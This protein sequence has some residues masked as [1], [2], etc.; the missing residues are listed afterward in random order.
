MAKTKCGNLIRAP[1]YQLIP[2][3]GGYL[4]DTFSINLN[5]DVFPKRNG[6]DDNSNGILE[7]PV[8]DNTLVGRYNKHTK[9]KIESPIIQ[10]Y[11]IIHSK[12][13]AIILQPRVY[14][15]KV[16]YISDHI[17]QADINLKNLQLSLINI[18]AP[19]KTIS[20]EFPEK[21]EKFYKDLERTVKDIYDRKL[22]NIDVD[23]T[24]AR[25]II[26][27]DFDAEVKAELFG[28][29]DCLRQKSILKYATNANNT[30][31]NNYISNSINS[32]N[33]M[34]I[35]SPNEFNNKLVDFAEKNNFE[36]VSI[37]GNVNKIRNFKDSTFSLET[38]EILSD[39][40]Q[41]FLVSP[42]VRLLTGSCNVDFKK[43]LLG[44]GWVFESYRFIF[45]E[46]FQI[47]TSFQTYFFK[48]FRPNI[49]I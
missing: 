41:H 27:G 26:G 29:Y 7:L 45:F 14:L 5:F 35:K 42:Y 39:R 18:K 36:I 4:I 21:I 24:R 37:T 8:K 10:K 17:L 46:K 30:I 2:S 33:S 23:P 9:Q 43:G 48:N 20:K 6:I 12:N 19:D 38:N 25:I 47:T 16:E 1:L 15:T 3:G 40:G 44:F 34:K 22:K 31:P 13:L 49:N 32:N 28:Y 11:K